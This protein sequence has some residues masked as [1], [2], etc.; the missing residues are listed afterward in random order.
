MSRILIVAL[1][2]YQWVV[3]PYLGPTCRFLPS[4][5]EYAIDALRTHG[6]LR[7]SAFA[8]RRVLR[9]H[10]WHPGGCDPVPDHQS[11]RK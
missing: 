1:R 9:C 7:G 8:V 2:V 4:C 5:S 3:S 10:P 11:D 6:V